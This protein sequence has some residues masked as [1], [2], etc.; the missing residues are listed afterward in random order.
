MKKKLNKLK[1]VQNQTEVKNKMIDILDGK[2]LTIWEDN[3]L[4]FLGTPFVTLNFDKQTWNMFL[5]DIEKVVKK[6]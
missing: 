1:K 4:V 6:E 5:E 3:G 2:F